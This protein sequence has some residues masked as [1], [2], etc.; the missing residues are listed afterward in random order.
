MDYLEAAKERLAQAE[1]LVHK[2]LT[3]AHN[4]IRFNATCD[5]ASAHARV[6][7]LEKLTWLCDRAEEAIAEGE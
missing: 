4:A 1:E 7:L 2:D 5:L 6:G 3:L